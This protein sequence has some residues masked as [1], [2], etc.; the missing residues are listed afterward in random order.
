M[1]RRARLLEVR[2]GASSLT[3]DVA[4]EGLHE[5]GTDE[6]RWASA[7]E[8]N[9]ETPSPIAAQRTGGNA[10][11]VKWSRGHQMRAGQVEVLAKAARQARGAP[12]GSEHR[13]GWADLI[14]LTP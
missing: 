12:Y 7:T 4:N 13:V 2:L 5:Y 8:I 1:A 14:I 11:C 9:D 10:E 3:G 6:W